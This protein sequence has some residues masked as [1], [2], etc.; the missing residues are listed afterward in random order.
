MASPVT[1]FSFSLLSPKVQKI[2][3]LN[4]DSIASML[5]DIT[6]VSGDRCNTPSGTFNIYIGDDIESNGTTVIDLSENHG[7]A[8][9]QKNEPLRDV[10]ALLDDTRPSRL[11]ES[12]DSIVTQDGFSYV[13]ADPA[14]ANVHIVTKGGTK[15]FVQPRPDMTG[16]AAAAFGIDDSGNPSAAALNTVRL[17]A[18]I[19]AAHANGFGEIYMGRSTFIESVALK[20]GVVLVGGSASNAPDDSDGFGGHFAAAGSYIYQVTGTNA[21]CVYHAHTDYDGDGINPHKDKARGLGLRNI[22]LRG[23]GN[24]SETNHPVGLK[25]QSCAFIVLDQVFVQNFRRNVHLEDCFDSSIMHLR[26]GDAEEAVWVGNVNATG[27]NS[28]NLKFYHPRLE[29]WKTSGLTFKTGGPPPLQN[30]KIDIF[31]LKIEGHPDATAT[32]ALQIDGNFEIHFWGGYASIMGNSAPPSS[33]KL[34]DLNCSTHTLERVSFNTFDVSINGNKN[35]IDSLISVNPS[36][37]TISALDLDVSCIVQP[38]STL[39]N[40]IINFM[41]GNYK[42]ITLRNRFTY[43]P[44]NHVLWNGIANISQ[45]ERVVVAG[46]RSFYKSIVVKHPTEVASIFLEKEDVGSEWEFRAKN[47]G[48]LGVFNN[49]VEAFSVAANGNLTQAAGKLSVKD[50]EVLRVRYSSPG[51]IQNSVTICVADGETWDP[52]SVGSGPYLA[53][54]DGST[55]RK[56]SWN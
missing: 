43:N 34:V 30:N 28:N 40:G 11:F 33:F 39:A 19:D 2:Q 47:D 46:D 8:I 24:R 18:A 45:H 53:A 50:G 16:Y 35:G 17:Q 12:G 56:I 38:G 41:P 44:D 51:T 10:W 55:W 49:N 54:F 42:G 27:D 9:L 29:S 4:Y 31:G 6:L 5:E 36:G 7:Q 1:S 13:I 32:H 3:V 15:L 52:A 25:L 21:P 23:Q 26:T 37:R 14:E 20:P 48:G 22:I